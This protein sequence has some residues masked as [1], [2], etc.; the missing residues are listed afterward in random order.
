MDERLQKALEFG[1]Y[2][3]TLNNQKK[4]L[5]EKFLDQCVYYTQGHRFSVDQN[6]INNCKT[7]IDLG[8]KL[9]VV[10]IDDHHNPC[11]VDDL[12]VFLQEILHIYFS[13]LNEYHTEFE[14]IKGQRSIMD[15][16]D[17]E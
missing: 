12:Q 15:I 17:H 6:L 5:K 8:H 16:V 1:N 3:V 7:L 11:R 2:T 9:D 4:I 14:K 10:M 13:N